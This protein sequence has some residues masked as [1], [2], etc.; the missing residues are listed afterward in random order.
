[1][2]SGTAIFGPGWLPGEVVWAGKAD[3]RWVQP[4]AFLALLRSQRRATLC[5]LRVAPID[6]GIYHVYS[7]L[8]RGERVFDEEVEAKVFVSLLRE[9]ADMILGVERYGLKLKD[10]ARV[11]QKTPDGMT[12]TVA[13]ASRR[14]S[15]DAEFREDLNELDRN[16]ARV[17][18]RNEFYGGMACLAPF[19][20]PARSGTPA[21]CYQA[22]ASPDSKP[23]AK[24]LGPGGAAPSS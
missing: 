7:R 17:S 2:R 4:L 1:M 5:L 14:R 6:G 22:A 13:R 15:V 23:S 24:R 3:N 18:N 20:G 12:K 16:M 21:L 19:W 10:L 9:V 8:G 11:L